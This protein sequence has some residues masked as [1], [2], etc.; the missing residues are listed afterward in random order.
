MKRL[1]GGWEDEK[2]KGE[3]S[4]DWLGFIHQFF[5]SNRI[6]LTSGRKTTD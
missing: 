2:Y 5:V 1:K 6:N 3:A 4:I